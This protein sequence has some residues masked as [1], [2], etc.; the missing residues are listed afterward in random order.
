MGKKTLYHE[1]TEAMWIILRQIK[2]EFV[3]Y[4]GE[5]LLFV[6]WR[7]L[8]DECGRTR[9]DPEHFPLNHHNHK[10]QHHHH[11]FNTIHIES[12]QLYCKPFTSAIS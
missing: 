5:E 12:S 9:C 1:Q 7:R 8:T 6:G 10:S 2:I 4:Y 11:H 3:A